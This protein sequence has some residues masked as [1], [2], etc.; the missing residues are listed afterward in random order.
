MYKIVNKGIAE[1]YKGVAWLIEMTGGD[2]DGQF[3]AV[4]EITEPRQEIMVMPALGN[5]EPN[6]LAMLFGRRAEVYPNVDHQTA[7]DKFMAGERGSI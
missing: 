4:S 3:F 2:E 5:G 6:P 7:I 1:G